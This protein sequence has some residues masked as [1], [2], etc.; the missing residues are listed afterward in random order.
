MTQ[1]S[2]NVRKKKERIEE[3]VKSQERALDKFIMKEPQ[4]SCEN[5]IL[6]DHV[7]VN[8]YN[9][10]IKQTDNFKI[11]AKTVVPDV[12][13]NDAFYTLVIYDPRNW[14]ALDSNMIDIFT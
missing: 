3:L 2:R 11:D 1:D 4:V 7:D 12:E 14:D 13:K 8:I 5:Q 10:N 6:D 9:I